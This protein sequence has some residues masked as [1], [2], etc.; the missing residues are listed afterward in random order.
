MKRPFVR[1]IL[2][3]PSFLANP[4]MLHCPS[5]AER[6]FLFPNP[7]FRHQRSKVCCLGLINSDFDLKCDLRFYAIG[8]IYSMRTFIVNRIFAFVIVSSLT[9]VGSN[10]FAQQPARLPRPVQQSE[11]ISYANERTSVVPSYRGYRKAG[12]VKNSQTASTFRRGA[13]K[14]V[15]PKPNSAIV[16]SSKVQSTEAAPV[17]ESHL[18]RFSR[19]KVQSTA[20]EFPS[21]LL[22]AT[23]RT[24]SQTDVAKTRTPVKASPDFILQSLSDNGQKGLE[25][26][27]RQPMT[28]QVHGAERATHALPADQS[29]TT[30]TAPV[31]ARSS[32]RITTEIAEAAPVIDRSSHRVTKVQASVS[33]SPVE[34]LETTEAAPVINGSS[35]LIAKINVPVTAPEVQDSKPRTIEFD[36]PQIDV[37]KT[38]TPAEIS[39][40]EPAPAIDRSSRRLTKIRVPAPAPEV[41][42]ST[43]DLVA[44]A[45]PQIDV[46]KTR[47]PAIA[48]PN[49]KY[50]STFD[51]G[52]QDLQQS[53]WKPRAKQAQNAEQK[54]TL[55][56]PVEGKS[57]ETPPEIDDSNLFEVVESAFSD[58]NV[59][60]SVPLKAVALDSEEESPFTSL[61][62]EPIAPP[63]VKTENIA[64]KRESSPEEKAPIASTKLTTRAKLSTTRNVH[65]SV[66]KEDS[67]QS[68]ANEAWWFIL[69]LLVVPVLVLSGWA[70]LGRK[71]NQRYAEL[72]AIEI[73]AQ[74]N[75]PWQKRENDDAELSGEAKGEIRSAGFRPLRVESD[76]LDSETELLDEI[77][78]I[79]SIASSSN[80]KS[81]SKSN[82][83]SRVKTEK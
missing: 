3:K 43:P 28:E 70:L 75:T 78:S 10:V 20:P 19:G 59:A 48:F 33:A 37:V 82:S 36:Q 42:A 17:L 55:S 23:E 81:K 41:Q 49:F 73:P 69:P 83:D 6:Y 76:E 50:R 22:D 15:K 68:S 71:R 31:I 80:S 66:G 77:K 16:Y 44:P 4:F 46:V 58:E 30:E 57:L 54:V 26:S 13:R 29:E 52:R 79:S 45:Q 47:T 67:Q 24:E 12:D 27:Q 61:N 8:C 63:T 56:S 38:E 64:L 14:N 5:A 7:T 35:R 25:L 11:E 9:V 32:R 72:P 18:P 62:P 60:V 53:Q 21:S 34:Q 74:K 39:P 1:S 51:Y 65:T 40:T 2:I